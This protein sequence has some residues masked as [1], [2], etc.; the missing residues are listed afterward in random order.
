MGIQCISVYFLPN[1]KMF[2]DKNF[3]KIQQTVITNFHSVTHE[4]HPHN[5]YVTNSCYR[6]LGVTWSMERRKMVFQTSDESKG[7]GEVRYRRDT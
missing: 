7:F 5:I 2:L 1:T 3:Y 4:R 6:Q